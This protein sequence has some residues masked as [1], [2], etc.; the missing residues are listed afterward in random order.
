MRNFHCSFC[1]NL[2]LFESTACIGCSHRLAYD[3]EGRRMVAI[4]RHGNGTWRIAGGDRDGAPA[5]PCANY[6]G[7]GVCNWLA[8]QHASGGLCRSCELTRTVP[9]LADWANRE[10][11][12]RT[13]Q[14]KCRLLYSLHRLGLPWHSRRD[15]P[16][17]GLAFDILSDAD[18][19]D[20]M[21]TT[22]HDEGVITLSLQEADDVVR[23]DRRRHNREQ[24]RTVLG[25]FRHE[26]GHYYWNLLVRDA[27]RIDMFRRV[28]GS[29]ERDYCA[30]LERHY[31]EGPPADWQARFISAYAS[32]HPWEDFAETFAHYLHMADVLEIADDA[33]LALEPHDLEAPRLAPQLRDDA[34]EP[35]DG[36]MQRWSAL[37]FVLNNLN[38]GMGLRDA[39][40]FALNAAATAKLRFVHDLVLAARNG[41]R[42]SRETARE[43]T[44]ATG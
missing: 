43:M 10:P 25:H 36:L 34:E 1:G 38:R 39:Y 17:H 19:D 33:G 16:E 18:A 31:S 9:N 30:S 2:V 35:F 5:D 11:W 14:A 27:N 3:F 32:V 26:I 13:E 4:A 37:A 20:G 23:E 28:F 40:P 29:E 24:Y 12:S 7:Y 41:A 8:P 21:V 42:D 44:V 22:G 6:D 15:D